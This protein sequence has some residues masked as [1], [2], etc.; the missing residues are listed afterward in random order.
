MS[1]EPRTHSELDSRLGFMA[2]LAHICAAKGMRNVIISPGSRSAPLTAA[3]VRQP[4]ICERVIIDERA[5]AYVALGLAQ[6][7]RQPVGLVCTSGTATLN[8]APAVAEAFY[9]KIP[10]LLFTADR[11]PEWIDQQDNQAIHQTA[12]YAPHCRGAF[13]LP[14]DLRNADARWHADRIISE[15]INLAT[16]NAPGPVHVNV[17]LR[18]PL[19]GSAGNRQPTTSTPKLINTAQVDARLQDA[20]WQALAAQWRAA[21]RK[22]IVVGMSSP[23]ARLQRLLRQ[24]GTNPEVAVI[25][26]VTANLYPDG[27]QLI[28]SDAILGTRDETTLAALAPDLLV[29]LG[30]PLVSKYL[31]M[32]LRKN[33]P[34][35]HWHLDPAGEVADTFQ[36]LTDILPVEPVDCLQQLL[37]LRAETIAPDMVTSDAEPHEVTKTLPPHSV[38]AYRTEWLRLE[39]RSRPIL[40]DFLEA[41]PF[42]EF[43]AIYRIMQALPQN[44]VVQAGNSMVIRY[45]NFIGYLPHADFSAAPTAIFSN[46]GTSGIDGTVSSTVGAALASERITTLITG[47]LA[48][49]YDRN[50]LWHEHLPKNLRIVVLNNHGGGIFKMI[51][52]PNRLESEI[53]EQ[54]FFTPQ[55]LTAERSAADHGCDYLHC[56][57]AAE[58]PQ[59]LTE[60]F[61]RRDRA[62]ILEIT[63]DAE[64]NTRIFDDFKKRIAGF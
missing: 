7:T 27:T 16:G 30:G 13:E 61:Q 63:T 26:D 4:E 2:Q 62:T 15:A 23:N 54:Y 21:K 51:D 49:F 8:Y 46:R 3:F 28:H 14:V 42:G 17:P 22:L 25:G 50:G 34:A 58:L 56:A 52:G 38:A 9:Q 41:A 33:R 29:T 18:E 39:M 57:S 60:F 24:H 47:D 48:F 53:T 40:R 36:A 35:H 55:P 31:R 37:S 44:S 19:Y 20:E 10:L 5:A 45:I 12:M 1:D 11:P 64:V 43:Q 6:Q 32:H 59:S